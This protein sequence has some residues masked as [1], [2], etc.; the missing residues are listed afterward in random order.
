MGIFDFFTKKL[1]ILKVRATDLQKHKQVTI[2]TFTDNTYEVSVGS[3]EFIDDFYTLSSIIDDE[4]DIYK[5]LEACEKTY[6][7]LSDFCRFC[8]EEDEGEL[9][10]FINCRDIGPELYMRLG[11]WDKAEKAIKLCI[12]ANAYYPDDGSEQLN[13]LAS[14]RNVA[15]T[16][17][18]Y[19]SQNPGCLQRN[20]YKILQFNGDEREHL[21]H[22]LRTSLLIIKE[23]SGNTN[24]L[25]CKTTATSL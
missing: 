15:T 10:P 14:Y 20:M 18:S 9:P 12:E 19:I 6:P 2:T 22:F 7:L 8:I 5:K 21:K 25:Y 3:D 4:K 24:K 23:K 17:L 11:E 1:Q 16:A 13:D